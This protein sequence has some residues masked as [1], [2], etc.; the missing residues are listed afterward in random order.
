VAV[1]AAVIAITVWLG[2]R[3]ATSGDTSRVEVRRGDLA[4]GVD[5]T[6]TLE[7]VDCDRLGPPKVDGMWQFKI[8]MMAPEGR[9]VDAGDP[10]L[11]FD[12][13]ELQRRLDRLMH[14][15]DAAAKEVEQLEVQAA[16]TRR[17]DE[18]AVAKAEADLRK[19]RLA[20]EVPAHIVPGI[21]LQ[22]ARLDLD[23][24]RTAL[25]MTKERVTANQASLQ[26][27]LEGLRNTHR[28]K[29]AEQ[30][31]LVAAIASMTRKAQ[32]SGILLHTRDWRDEKKK[33]GDVCWRRDFVIEIPDLEQLRG[34]G[35][36]K[37]AQS[38]RVREGQP[39][40]LRLEALP[41]LELTGRVGS[42]SRVIQDASSSDDTKIMR[43]VIELDTVDPSRMRPGM[44]FRGTIETERVEDVLLAPAEAV[45]ASP[46][47]PFAVVESVTGPRRRNLVLGARSESVVEIVEG[48]TEGQ[49]LVVDRARARELG[50]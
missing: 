6:G 5:V 28:Q 39:V 50:R 29:L 7:A 18:L 15:V 25:R 33:V 17:D 34:Q 36:V 16:R 41:D 20:A 26:A 1:A 13:S 37:E 24:A 44:R 45:F 31:R 21:E 22:K 23:L 47:G 40:R 48:L 27:Q 32:R 46:D 14:E 8:A 2:V 49:R 42:V 3:H 30:Q 10:V 4:I 19:A 38:G 35:E 9:E 11:A 12:A 43:L